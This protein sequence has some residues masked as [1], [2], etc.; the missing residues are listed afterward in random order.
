M[1]KSYADFLGFP[2]PQHLLGQKTEGMEVDTDLHNFALLHTTSSPPFTDFDTVLQYHRW[3]KEQIDRVNLSCATC[4]GL[5][6]PPSGLTPLQVK[7][8]ASEEIMLMCLAYSNENEYGGGFN[9]PNV[10]L[11][12]KGKA[13]IESMIE[14][15]I[16]IDLSHAGHRTA[17]NALDF[18]QSLG[19]TGRVVASH[20]ACY[21]KY[22]HLR[23]LPDDVLCSI[24]DLGGIIGLPTITWL[25]SETDNTLEP[26]FQHLE[27]LIKYVGVEN[28]AI[29]SDGVYAS[30]DKKE[31]ASRFEF[32]KSNLDPTGTIFHARLPEECEDIHGPKRMH[33][34]SERITER[35]GEKTSS[36]ITSKNLL[37][38]FMFQT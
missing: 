12:E 24:A 18:I 34:L 35:F 31:E 25:L 9:A 32:M 27:H 19:V 21:S 10:P 29:G 28:V 36:L 16:I 26:F 5:Q 23:N 7:Q 11:S 22:H 2:F 15:D 33:I 20:S 14:E 6:N 38:W 37:L 1:L 8:L 17:R 3:F 30:M 13:L 4:Y